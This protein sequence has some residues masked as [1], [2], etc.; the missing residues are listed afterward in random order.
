MVLFFVLL[1]E[2]LSCK[3]YFFSILVFLPISLFPFCFLDVLDSFKKAILSK[4][5]EYGIIFNFKLLA[6][7]VY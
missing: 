2:L 6:F 1:E 7:Y 4:A 3:Q 5:I